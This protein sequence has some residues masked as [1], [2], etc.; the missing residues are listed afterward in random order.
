MLFSDVTDNMIKQFIREKMNNSAKNK[1]RPSMY[2][3]FRLHDYGPGDS[4]QH[5]SDQ[6][7]LPVEQLQDQEIANELLLDQQM[8]T[9]EPIPGQQILE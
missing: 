8:H 4:G 6:N 9:I 5:I 7:Q 3:K 1:G 2:K